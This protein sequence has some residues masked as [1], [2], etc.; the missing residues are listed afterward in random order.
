M[1]FKE[2]LEEQ[3]VTLIGRKIGPTHKKLFTAEMAGKRW[4]GNFICAREG[5]TTLE[6]APS[7]I[8][9][10][11]FDC[12]TNRLTSLKGIPSSVDGFVNCAANK[13]TSLHDIH[14]L[15]KNMDGVFW[16]NSNPITSCILGVLLIRGCIGLM[17]DNIRVKNII[18]KHLPNNYGFQGVLACQNELLDAGFDE[19]AKL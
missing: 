10:G 11:A 15:I 8:R 12:S 14:K 6:G 1:R 7:I 19:Y 3:E 2:L 13:L 9:N 4:N 18:I 5:L 16:A 17:I